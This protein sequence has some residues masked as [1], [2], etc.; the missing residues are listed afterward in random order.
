MAQSPL[1]EEPESNLITH[2]PKLA[3]IPA[4]SRGPPSS[5]V[6]GV[7][8]W[9]LLQREDSSIPH[10]IEA[11]L[12]FIEA[13]GKSNLIFF[14]T[15]YRALKLF[16]SHLFQGLTEVGIYRISGENRVVHE[17][18]DA[19]NKGYSPSTLLSTPNQDVHNITSLVKLFLREL[20]DPLIPHSFYDAFIEANSVEG[21]DD[22][23]YAIRDLVWKLPKSHFSLLRRLAEHM[24]K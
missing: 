19:L 14:S 16:F 12:E 4:A 15:K 9:E 11:A 24:D 18:K 10:F 17:M 8:L 7:P 5:L 22:R 2:S 23:L 21:Y 6:F 20:P 3:T 13:R 1:F